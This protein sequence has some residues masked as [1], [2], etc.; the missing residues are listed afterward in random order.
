VQTPPAFPAPQAKPTVAISPA[1]RRAMVLS[2]LLVAAALIVVA[3]TGRNVGKPAWWIGPVSNP[4]PFFV[5][6]LPFIGPAAS[7]V[8]TF[9]IVRWAHIIG[10]AS[11]ALIA[12]VA[13]FDINNSPGIALIEFVV[14]VAAA[15]IA[16]ASF[17]GRTKSTA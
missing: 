15:L 10:L 14:A 13:I 4:T 17:A 9:R 6:A 12:V 2:W 7:I 3:V 16:I 8:A 1:W 5:W 11:A